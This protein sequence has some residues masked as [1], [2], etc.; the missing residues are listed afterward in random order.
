VIARGIDVTDVSHVINV[1]VPENPELYTHRIGRTGRADKDG[2]AI[3]FVASYEEED[4]Q[5]IQDFMS[6]EVPEAPMPEGVEVTDIMIADERPVVSMPN[7][8]KKNPVKTESGGA[9]HEKKL[10]NLKVN[11]KLS[12]GDKM[13]LKYGKPKKRRNN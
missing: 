5:K 11:M 7:M 9:F 4:F 10:K 1:D 3:T 13:K 2:I 8:E 6:M 12:R